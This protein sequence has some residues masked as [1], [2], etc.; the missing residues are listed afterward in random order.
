M[1]SYNFFSA[2]SSRQKPAGS[3]TSAEH[4]DHDFGTF[5]ELKAT[6]E[7]LSWRKRLM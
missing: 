2:P 5:S 6:K 1:V 3:L 7:A 4:K